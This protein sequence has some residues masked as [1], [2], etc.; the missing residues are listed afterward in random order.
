M[1]THLHAPHDFRTYY[2]FWCA[3]T[4]PSHHDLHAS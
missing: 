4:G 3:E 1:K 2:G